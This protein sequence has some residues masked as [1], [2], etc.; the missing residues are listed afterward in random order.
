MTPTLPTRY[1]TTLKKK[2]NE[3]ERETHINQSITPIPAYLPVP[4]PFHFL[5]G[6]HLLSPSKRTNG[7]FF[8]Y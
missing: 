1:V 3:E 6:I 4:F 7:K 5:N 2:R 8:F